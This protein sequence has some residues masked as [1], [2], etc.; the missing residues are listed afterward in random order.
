MVESRWWVP[1]CLKD[2]LISFAVCFEKFLNSIGKENRHIQSD[3]YE[4]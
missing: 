4:K 1:R 3:N 2:C